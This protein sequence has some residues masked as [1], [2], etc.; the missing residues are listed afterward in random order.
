MRNLILLFFFILLSISKAHACMGPPF[1]FKIFFNTVPKEPPTG[2]LIAKVTVLYHYQE[3]AKVIIRE[4]FKTPNEKI[5]EG[6]T[7]A[8]EYTVTSC[9]PH[10][11]ML[12]TG[13]IMANVSADKTGKL[14]LHPYTYTES[15]NRDGK[16]YPPEYFNK[17]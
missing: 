13:I 8:M 2:V 12:K 7:V 14:V 9:G 15:S 6:S 4:I 17:P 11:E 1:E 16:F 3:T 10:L 5:R